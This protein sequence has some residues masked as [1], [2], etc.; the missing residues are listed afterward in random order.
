V[1]CRC[2]GRPS[3]AFIAELLAANANAGDGRVAGMVGI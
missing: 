1:S 3:Q 2:A